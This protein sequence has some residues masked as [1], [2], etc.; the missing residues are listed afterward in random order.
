MTWLICVLAEQVFMIWFGTYAHS[1]AKGAQKELACLG[2]WF[3]QKLHSTGTNLASPIR[4][5]IMRALKQVQA[6][7]PEEI[8]KRTADIAR[9]RKEKWTSDELQDAQSK[10][11]EYHIRVANPVRR[12]K[13]KAKTRGMPKREIDSKVKAFQKAERLAIAKG[14]PSTMSADILTLI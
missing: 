1:A 9:D 7:T 3:G 12:F 11:H 13:A 6:M 14:D 4:T 5:D 10:R 2:P 8:N